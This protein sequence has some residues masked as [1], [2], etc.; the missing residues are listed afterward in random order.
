[1]PCISPST[2]ES[3]ADLIARF[4][5]SPAEFAEAAGTGCIDFID[6]RFAVLHYPLDA[7][8]ELTLSTAVYSAVP[9][10]YSLLDQDAMFSSG[11]SSAWELPP[12]AGQGRG[13]MIGLIDTGIDY[14]NPLFRNRDGS[15]RILGIWD[16]TA[17]SSSAPFLTYGTQ[18]TK[19][20]IDLALRSDDPL[21]LVPEEDTNGHGTMMASLAAGK[22]DP[23][24]GFSGAAPQCALGIVK[25]KPAKQYLRRFFLI[26]ET[27]AA[28]QENDIMT[29]IRYLYELAR[30]QS[31]P[32]VVCLGLGTNFGSHTGTSPLGLMI[33]EM[34]TVNGVV[35][36]VAAGNETGYGHHASHTVTE[37]EQTVPV[38]LSVGSISGSPGGFSMEFCAEGASVFDLAFLSP[39]GRRISASSS[40]TMQAETVY[41]PVEKTSI[42]IYSRLTSAYSG[43]QLIY[44][45]FQDPAPGIWTL[46][47]TCTAEPAGTFHIRLPCHGFIDD[48]IY[49]LRP[50]PDSLITE[51]GN[52]RYP[53][54]VGAIDHVTGGI[55]IHSGRG[56]SG[57][58]QIK[59]ELAAPGV[60]LLAAGL[61]PGIFQTVTGTSAAA[62]IAAGAAAILLNRGIVNGEDP[63]MNSSTIKTILIRGAKRNPALLYPNRESGYGMLD[64]YQAFL[65][66]RV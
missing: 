9:A 40:G 37:K 17:D 29:G 61:R 22:E 28:Y 25:L 2:S 19:N 42:T 62:A 46:A 14:Q 47:V 48:D 52:A 13:V 26:N 59:P 55:Y 10:L 50:D 5:T 6:H 54:T 27:A 36:V 39:T 53:L 16:Q 56:Y 49:F 51:P 1:M 66:L 30:S 34:S 11:I 33:D 60:R 38:E 45:R 63:F 8:R 44:L 12:L 24:S 65:D 41:F 21:S 23:E 4:Q 18:Y 64:L 3:T 15:T 35:F 43:N 58:G 32:L 57:S 7:V 20:Q 31:M